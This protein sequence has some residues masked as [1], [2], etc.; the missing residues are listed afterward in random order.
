MTITRRAALILPLA[1]HAASAR[2]TTAPPIEA[3]RDPGCGCCEGWAQH[4]RAA[5]FRVTMTD[6]RDLPS[7]RR[8]AGVPEDLA[9][10]HFARMGRF[11]LEGH[12]PAAAVR[13][14]LA[15]PGDWRGLAVPGMPMG[16]PGMEMPGHSPETYVIVAFGSNGRDP[17]WATA[18][19][20]A[21]L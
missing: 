1:A 14:F 19:G 17:A 20:D 2:A 3:F 12:V 18:R 11:V 13:R 15:T 10:C 5:G 8:G 16:S 9:G 7:L 21:L 4:L 6:H